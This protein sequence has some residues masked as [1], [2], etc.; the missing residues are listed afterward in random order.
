MPHTAT[1]IFLTDIQQL[2]CNTKK[3]NVQT[4]RFWVEV[5]GKEGLLTL[6][7]GCLN[8]GTSVFHPTT[9]PPPPF[10]SQGR[11][12]ARMLACLGEGDI[13]QF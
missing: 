9:A 8:P 1:N 7:H 12:P 13:L 2:S 10:D 4:K 3:N 6:P 11:R 5:V